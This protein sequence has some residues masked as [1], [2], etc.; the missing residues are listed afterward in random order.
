MSD[1]HVTFRDLLHAVNLRHGTNRFTSLLKEGVLRIFSSWKIRRLR[2]GLNPRTWVPK[3]STLP[4]DHRSRLPGSHNA[5][6]KMCT[7]FSL[8]MDV[9]TGIAWRSPLRHSSFLADLCQFHAFLQP[10]LHHAMNLMICFACRTALADHPNTTVK[11]KSRSC[12]LECTG[13]G[14]QTTTLSP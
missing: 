9:L 7:P 5:L 11:L 4:L 13:M 14:V 3:A 10:R 1:F 8:C 2:P 12:Y 6:P